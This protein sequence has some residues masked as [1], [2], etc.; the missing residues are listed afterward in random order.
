MGEI[1]QQSTTNRAGSLT[2]TKAA[3]SVPFDPDVDGSFYLEIH[4]HDEGTV[5]RVYQDDF[6]MIRGALECSLKT[7]L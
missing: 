1:A 2:V 7:P 3:L 4:D 6:E 5:I